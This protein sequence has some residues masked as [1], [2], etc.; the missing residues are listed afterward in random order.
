V[1]LL[2]CT[3]CDDIRKMGFAV[4]KCKCGQS[5]GQ[6]SQGGTSV[7][8]WGSNAYAIGIHNMDLCEAVT[9][10]GSPAQNGIRAWLKGPDHPGVERRDIEE[11]TNDQT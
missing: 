1:N 2:F 4:T 3:S 6:Y 9:T 8:I 7:I 10:Y 5:A 11:L